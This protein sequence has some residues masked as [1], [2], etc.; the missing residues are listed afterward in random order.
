MT[1]QQPDPWLPPDEPKGANAAAHAMAQLR[2][3]PLAQMDCGTWQ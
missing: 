3:T 2:P 1:L